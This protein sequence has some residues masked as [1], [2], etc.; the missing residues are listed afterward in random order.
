VAQIIY[1]M[2]L[3]T[4]SPDPEELPEVGAYDLV[5]PNPFRRHLSAVHN[6]RHE[7]QSAQVSALHI[8][9]RHHYSFSARG[10]CASFVIVVTLAFIKLFRL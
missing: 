4:W 7:A 10:R 1:A 5:S 3:L 8:V 2:S 9:M 6:I